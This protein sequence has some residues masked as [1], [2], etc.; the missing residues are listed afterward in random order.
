MKHYFY[1][2][3]TA[4]KV[5]VDTFVYRVSVGSSSKEQTKCALIKEYSK[6]CGFYFEKVSGS[7]DAAIR[8][9]ENSLF[10]G[11]SFFTSPLRRVTISVGTLYDMIIDDSFIFFESSF[12]EKKG[13]FLF[14]SVID[15]KILFINNK[16]KN[17]LTTA[18]PSRKYLKSET[19]ADFDKFL[20]GSTL[21]AII[22]LCA[23]WLEG[24]YGYIF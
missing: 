18:F 11:T 8:H 17:L 5:T 24:N 4:G 6:D 3:R 21:V 22:F 16:K 7:S 19:D 13:T 9:L 12:K 23:A 10:P 14:H 1:F 2:V 15:P 20:I